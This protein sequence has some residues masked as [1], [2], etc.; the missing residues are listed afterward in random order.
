[1]SSP[2][3]IL[4]IPSS[5]CTFIAARKNSASIKKN[6][7]SSITFVYLYFVSPKLRKF[8][9]VSACRLIHSTACV[10]SSQFRN[11][12]AKLFAPLCVVFFPVTAGVV[13]GLASC[14]YNHCFRNFDPYLRSLKPRAHH[15]T[16]YHNIYAIFY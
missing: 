5:P 7:I 11:A 9:C 13:A 10:W 8:K 12:L 1:M 3:N 15:K 6:I 14:L 2:S 4:P 16:G